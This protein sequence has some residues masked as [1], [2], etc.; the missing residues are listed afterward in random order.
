MWKGTNASW[1]S[2]C[3][4]FVTFTGQEHIGWSSNVAK[5][6]IH[7]CPHYATRDTRLTHG[8]RKLRLAEDFEMLR[9]TSDFEILRLPCDFKI[10]EITCQTQYFKIRRQTQHFK[11][12]HQTQDFKII[13]RTLFSVTMRQTCIM[14]PA[15][16][17]S[18]YQSYE[19]ANFFCLIH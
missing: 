14:S 5:S 6:D 17:A 3:L 12:R 2:F 16:Q 15:M 7:I 18:Q 19:L 13:R 1:F 9:M 10:F 8:H 11:I 4:Y